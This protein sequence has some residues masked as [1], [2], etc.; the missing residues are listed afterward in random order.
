MANK[1]KIAREYSKK[2][3]KPEY[4]SVVKIARKMIGGG[5]GKS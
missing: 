4:K 2:V 5:Y 3:K 1:A